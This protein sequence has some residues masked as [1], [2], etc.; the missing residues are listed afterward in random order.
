[1]SHGQP[2]GHAS[3]HNKWI[4]LCLL[5]LYI[6]FCFIIFFV[7]V[8]PSLD[9]QD[10]LKVGAD[11]TTY[12]EAAESIDS[13]NVIS[14]SPTLISFQGQYL[15]PV[16]VALICGT[17]LNIALFNTLLFIIGLWY[18]SRL[19]GLRIGILLFLIAI[20]PITTVS[21]L[22]LNKEIFSYLSVILFVCY[23]YSTKRTKTM[24]TLILL[25]SI[26]ARWEQ[27]A[28]ILLFL[29]VEHRW[30]PVKRR[31]WAVIFIM[32]GCITI[33]WPILVSSGIIQ[34]ASLLTTAKEAQSQ[35][36]PWLN[37]IQDSYGFPV[38]L[39][40]KIIGNMFGIPWKIVINLLHTGSLTDI[41][42]QLVSPLQ[43]LLMLLI[44]IVAMLKG[45]LSLQSGTIYWMCLYLIMSAVGPIFQPRYE[46]PVYVLLCLEI[47]GLVSPEHHRLA[48]KPAFAGFWKGLRYT[49]VP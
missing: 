15:G 28:I 38:V 43:N 7:Y 39:I 40:P 2:I 42:D 4:F 36:L 1:M 29:A 11:S 3:S 35:S 12:F 26:A 45:K 46:Y 8:K 21:I 23:I 34:L 32:I 48:C 47:C 22:T 19:P 6:I 41:Q 13:G 18:A 25:I 31:R 17:T 20:N 9:G 5:L 33:T 14:S 16:L 49:P 30:S 27:A 44:F 24:L 37:K 10:N